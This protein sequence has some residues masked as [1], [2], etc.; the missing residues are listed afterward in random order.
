[1]GQIGGRTLAR[2]SIREIQTFLSSEA[3][4]EHGIIRS[5]IEESFCGACATR[6]D[7]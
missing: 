3:F 1:M 4:W 7:Y 5:G 6:S 2:G